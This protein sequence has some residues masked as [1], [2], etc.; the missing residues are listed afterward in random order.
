MMG[1]GSS[2]V[3]NGREN[4]SDKLEDI[5]LTNV[6]DI[7]LAMLLDG[8]VDAVWLYAD[9][10]ERYQCSNDPDAIHDFNCDIWSGFGEKFAY[11]QTGMFD[12][13]I[14]GTTISISKKGSGLADIINPCLDMFMTKCQYR[15]ICEKY[16]MVEAC[17]GLD[18]DDSA[19]EK[20]WRMPTSELPANGYSCSNGYCSCDA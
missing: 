5:T 19:S 6:N 17:I 16:D 14:N 18:D 7:G 8:T 10:A 1:T 11:I 20:P 3:W 12:H 13:A 9:Q 2:Y 4:G 15:E